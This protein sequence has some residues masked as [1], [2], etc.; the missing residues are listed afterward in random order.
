MNPHVTIANRQAGALII[1]ALI[2]IVIFSIGILALVGLLSATT[3]KAGDAKYR[4]DASL[5]A[6]Q[7][8]GQMWASDR[9]QAVLQNNFSSPAGPAYVAWASQVASA[10]PGVTPTLMPTVAVSSVTATAVPSSYIT[11]TM[12]WKAPTDAHPHRYVSIAQ[13]L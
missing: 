12:Q 5:L 9:T 3:N 4:A 8:I 13:I 2:S 6:N 10:L 7:L 1:E 11:I